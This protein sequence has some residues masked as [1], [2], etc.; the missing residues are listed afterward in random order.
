MRITFL[1]SI[2]TLSARRQMKPAVETKFTNCGQFDGILGRNEIQFTH[3]C[4]SPFPSC[5][6]LTK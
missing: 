2:L 5:M 1:K 3:C 4:G 6:K